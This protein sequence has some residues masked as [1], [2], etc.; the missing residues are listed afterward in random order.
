MKGHLPLKYSLVYTTQFGSLFSLTPFNQKELCIR[1][2]QFVFGDLIRIKDAVNKLPAGLSFKEFINAKDKRMF[3]TPTQFGKQRTKGC[4]NLKEAEIECHTWSRI[5]IDEY[6][7]LASI[8]K[9]DVLV[10]LMEEPNS[11]GSTRSLRR[12][13]EKARIFLERTLAFRHESGIE[14]QVYA[15]YIS[16]DNPYVQKESLEHLKKNEKEIDGIFLTG[17]FSR[18]KQNPY[19]NRRKIFEL[20]SGLDTRKFLSSKGDPNS[21]ME[22]AYYGVDEFESFFPFEVAKEGL[23]FQFCAKKW[24]E[25]VESD[26]TFSDPMTLFEKNDSI[27]TSFTSIDLSKQIYREDDSPLS[28]GC[29]CYACRD[30][31]RA[32]LH[33]LIHHKEMTATVLLVIHN[34]WVYD[35]IFEAMN[36]DWFQENKDKAISKFFE[37]FSVKKDDNSS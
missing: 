6:L 19:T 24:K 18:S 23:A 36:S 20:L 32:Y 35:R 1:N 34:C 4:E 11:E 22:G 29:G 28:E 17:V 31:S 9:P 33:H 30:I 5:T 13:A 14:S 12:S 8:V 26:T 27:L 21:I 3:L 15:N 7:R 10:S 37:L 16:G 2:L 25:A